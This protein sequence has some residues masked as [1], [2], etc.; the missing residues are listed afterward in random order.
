MGLRDYLAATADRLQA[1][2]ARR[3][4]THRHKPRPLAK[5]L[6][7]SAVH[8]ASARL[9]RSWAAFVISRA[10]SE[11]GQLRNRLMDIDR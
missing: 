5:M 10:S 8:G 4:S 11:L 3:G 7:A 2:P 1:S 6:K 9:E